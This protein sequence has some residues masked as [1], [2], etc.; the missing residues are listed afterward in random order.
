MVMAPQPASQRLHLYSHWVGY[1]QEA[2]SL[3]FVC[4]YRTDGRPTQAKENTQFGKSC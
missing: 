3:K 2:N 4:H 1:R